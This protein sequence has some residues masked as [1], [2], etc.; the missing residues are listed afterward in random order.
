VGVQ[1]QTS[2]AYLSKLTGISFD[3]AYPT[4]MSDEEIAAKMPK[5]AIPITKPYNYKHGTIDILGKVGYKKKHEHYGEWGVDNL[6]VEINGVHNGGYGEGMHS[7]RTHSADPEL[8]D[9]VER[10][11]GNN[12][13]LQNR[14]RNFGT[15]YEYRLFCTRCITSHSL[16][17]D[18]VKSAKGVHDDIIMF[19]V[20]HRHDGGGNAIKV[21]A[22]FANVVAS[23]ME[24][25]TMATGG[26]V[27]REDD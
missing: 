2:A 18:Q 8:M 24:P 16:S 21:L 9:R 6:V 13:Q 11:T 27:F 14:S 23:D 17:V 5:T 22:T 10:A 1:S 19:A 12:V 7:S 25:T 4:P 15:A 26:R 3:H 20:K